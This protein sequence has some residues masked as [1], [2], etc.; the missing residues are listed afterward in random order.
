MSCAVTS[1][2]GR[3]GAAGA[4]AAGGGPSWRAGSVTTPTAAL[5]T[6]AATATIDRIGRTPLSISRSCQVS[7]R[8][9]PV[10]DADTLKRAGLTGQLRGA[11]GHAVV[12]Q[13]ERDQIQVAG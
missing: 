2:S 1:G 6:M 8:G 13:Q 5:N 7:A 3:G 9:R 11:R 4:V 10:G 12:L